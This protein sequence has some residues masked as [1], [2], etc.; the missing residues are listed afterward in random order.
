MSNTPLQHRNW[1]GAIKKNPI[2]ENVANLGT[3]VHQTSESHF[4][5]GLLRSFSSTPISIFSYLFLHV[6]YVFTM[7]ISGNYMHIGIKG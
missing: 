7:G 1:L 6:Q 5:G 2:K 4:S 3:S